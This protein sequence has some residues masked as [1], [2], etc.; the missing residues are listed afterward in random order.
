MKKKK[1]HLPAGSKL[2]ASN[3]R[4]HR[5]YDIEDRFETGI[6]LQGT[7]VKSLRD[8]KIQLKDSYAAFKEG[9]LWLLN[10]H[11][12]EYF[13][14]SQFN[15]DPTRPRKL[16]MKKREL[17]KLRAKVQQEGYTLIPLSV[18]FKKS[19]VKVELG[20]CRGKKQYD[21]RQDIAKKEAQRQID[22]ALKRRR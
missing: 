11:I 3:R 4:A 17:Q 18:Y 21:Q 2:I 10:S 12:N 15:H 5:D 8:G 1:H 16:L 6:V 22:R 7:E 13:P 19:W 14:A 9:E 20:L